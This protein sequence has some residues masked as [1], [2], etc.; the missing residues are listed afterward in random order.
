MSGLSRRSMAG[1]VALG[2]AG[3]SAPA[4]A[5]GSALPPL[6][7]PL[8]A[9]TADL[10]R[11]NRM[12]AAAVGA[13]LHGR[14]VLAD[15]LGLASLPFNAP[16]TARTLFHW[17]SA[18]KHLTAALVVRLALEGRVDLGDPVGRHVAGLPEALSGLPI[19]NLLS[20]TSGAPDY[21]L[22]GGQPDLAPDRHIDRATFL[23][24]IAAL[25][26]DFAPGQVWSYSN[27]GY[28]LLGYLIADV[29]GRPYR[30]VV[31]DLLLKPAGLDEGR[32]DDAPAVIMERAEPYDLDNG[33][34]RHAV[35][36]DA[37]FSAWPDGGVLMSARDAARW[38]AGLQSGRQ[39]SAEALRRMTTADRLATGRGAAYGFGWFLD[40]VHGR[41]VHYHGG[42]VPGFL[43]FYIRVPALGLGVVA[44]TNVGSD[45]GG[46]GV[47]EIAQ[48]VAEHLA[49]GCTWRSLQP[50]A[51]DHPDLTAAARAILTRGK[52]PLDPD[53]Y[54]PEIASVIGRPAGRRAGPPNL[55]SL[56]AMTGFS[57]IEAYRDPDGEIRRYRAAFADQSVDVVFGYAADG[58]IFRARAL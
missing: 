42:S 7:P 24:K 34:F 37:E 54:G 5:K 39:V 1:L 41:E 15:A 56:G 38:E 50:I 43:T 20:H 30:D 22:L 11:R 51:D 58:R 17:G 18:S 23:A 13:V 9:R 55:A 46:R 28:V 16:A 33:V 27:T 25:K 2:L 31:T 8:R 52:T 6:A 4:W 36:M 3:A 14:P 26:P 47:Q 48:M 53:R 10:I 32:M 35:T 19:H 29:Y 44:M 21:A 49:P 12:P 45:G 57:L 40:R